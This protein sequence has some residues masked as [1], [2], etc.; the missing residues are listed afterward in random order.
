YIAGDSSVTIKENAIK[1]PS[2][3]ILFGEKDYDSPH[4]YMDF[5]VLDDIRQLDQSKHSTG[6]KDVKGN[7]GGGSNHA[8]VDGSARFLKFGRAFDPINLWAVVPEIRNIAVVQ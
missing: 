3:T 2:Q 8:F 7:G 6:R 4:Y 1:D 5:E